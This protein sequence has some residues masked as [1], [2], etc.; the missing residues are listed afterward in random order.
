MVSGDSGKLLATVKGFSE[1]RVYPVKR[2]ASLDG[3]SEDFSEVRVNVELCNNG[4]VEL[5][6]PSGKSWLK[7]ILA[8]SQVKLDLLS[9]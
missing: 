7:Q 6:T 9:L 8:H 2:E 3:K 1:V 5:A 4:K